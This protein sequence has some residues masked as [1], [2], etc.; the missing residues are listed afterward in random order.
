MKEDQIGVITLYKQQV[1]LLTEGFK[2]HQ[3]IEILTA[4]KS[5]GRDKDCILMSLV[6]SNAEKKVSW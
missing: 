4:D 2:D 3:D 1:K 5:Q 6:R